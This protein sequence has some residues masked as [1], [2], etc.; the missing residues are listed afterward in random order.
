MIY[1]CENCKNRH[2]CP[3]NQAQ[4]QRT[5]NLIREIA[6]A[7]DE[8][9]NYHCYYTLTVRCDYWCDDVTT[10]NCMEKEND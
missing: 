10:Y 7:L 4:Y 2:D 9:Q 6:R 3:E 8:T 1:R 5:C